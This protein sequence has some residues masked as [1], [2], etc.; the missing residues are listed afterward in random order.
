MRK[1]KTSTTDAG[2]A[3]DFNKLVESIFYLDIT[4]FLSYKYPMPQNNLA[5]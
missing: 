4:L 5:K 2:V 3:I 1:H